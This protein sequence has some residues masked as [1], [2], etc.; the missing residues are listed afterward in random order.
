MNSSIVLKKTQTQDQG[1]K[2][3][4]VALVSKTEI[5]GAEPVSGRLVEDLV[6]KVEE[7]FAKQK[8]S[9][10]SVKIQTAVAMSATMDE[11]Q[12]IFSESEFLTFR[13]LFFFGKK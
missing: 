7:F 13:Q 3:T 8:I 5:A 11:T 6:E 2:V 9:K 10:Q 4:Y 12:L 1:T